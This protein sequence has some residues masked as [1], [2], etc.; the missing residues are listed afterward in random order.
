M[1]IAST[2]SLTINAVP[3]GGSLNALEKRRF[4]QEHTPQ[5]DKTFQDVKDIAQGTQ[6]EAEAGNLSGAMVRAL[7]AKAPA[8]DQQNQADNVI[9]LGKKLGGDKLNQMIKV[10]QTYRQLER[11][12]PNAGQPSELCTTNKELDGLTQAQDPTG[13]GGNNGA[14]T[15]CT[16]NMANAT[17]PPKD[18]GEGKKNA[19]D[20]KNQDAAK[21]SKKGKK[22]DKGKK[23]KKDGKGKKNQDPTGTNPTG[24]ANGTS[25]DNGANPSGTQD[26]TANPTGTQDNTPN[27]TGTQDNTANPAGKSGADSNVNPAETQDPTGNG[28]NNG[29]TTTCTM[30][31]ANATPPPK[32]NGEGKKNA[33]DNKNQDAAKK[34]KKGKKKDKGKKNKKDGKGKKNQ[35][36]TGTNPTGAANG[37]SQ[38]NGANPSGTQDN[39]ANPTGT[40]DNTPNPTGTQDNT[41]NPT[42]TQDNTPNPTG[43]QDNT[44]NPA[45]KSGADS[46]VNPA[47]ADPLGGVQMPKIQKSNGAFI[48][49]GDRFVN[50][51]AAHTRQCDVQHNLCANKANGGDK[52]FTVGDCDTQNN[53]CKD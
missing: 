50:E 13:N 35:D 4:G 15:T 1:L 49:N 42:G 41:A 12:T 28:G 38:D 37:T 26:N 51:D 31:M 19:K 48:V 6:L 27:P 21:K 5:A 14:T 34:S 17:P 7:L 47:E 24:A 18:N 25:Q 22:K 46:N 43:T 8:C 52:S 40:Q 45:G 32:D 11:N 20:N 53:N 44:A 3:L 10:A 29:A 39:T 9:D 23:N 30:N 36:P 2:L 16:M 33:K